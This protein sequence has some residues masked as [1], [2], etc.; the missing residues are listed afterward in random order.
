MANNIVININ[1]GTAKYNRQLDQAKQKMR[2]TFGH[3]SVSGVQATS[4]ALRTLEG[5]MTN[6]IRAVERFL[7]TTLKLG[8]ALQAAFPLIGAAA[9]AG[10]LVELTSK[11]AAFFKEI[12]NA[13]EKLHGAF[14]DLNQ[15]LVVTN[16]ALAVSNARLENE[17]A[18]LSGQPTNNLKVALLEAKE[19]ADKLNESLGK[20]IASAYKLVDEQSGSFFKRISSGLLGKADF[21]DIGKELGGE[22]GDGGFRARIRGLSGNDAA[23]AYKEEIAKFEQQ[24]Q[25]AQNS[26]EYGTSDFFG[27]VVT[28]DMT[29]R[30]E[31][32]KGELFSL[33]QD[34][35]GIALT[36]TNSGLNTQVAKLQ[37]KNQAANLDK[38]FADKMAELSA[39]LDEVKA[40]M[41][42]VGSDPS[43]Q[44]VA[45]GAAAAAKDILE[46]NKALAKKHET[47][48][49]LQAVQVITADSNIASAEAE[50]K[51]SEKITETTKALDE[52][53]AQQRA[54]NAVE[55]S[56]YEARRNAATESKLKGT[57]GA[58]YSDSSKA[59][60]IEAV[61]KKLNEEADLEHNAQLR[62]ESAELA[63]QITLYTR[64]AQVAG[65]F[66]KSHAAQIDAEVAKMRAEGKY[67]EEQIAQFIRLDK[68]KQ[69]AASA[70][71]SAADVLS[72]QGSQRV[73][74]AAFGG[75]D[76]IRQAEIQ[77]AVAE[78]AAKGASAAEQKTLQA[79]LEA[80][81][82]AQ[83]AVEAAKLTTSYRDQMETLDREIAAIREQVA[84]HGADVETQTALRNLEDQRLKLAQQQ[85]L[86][87]DSATAG[88]RAFFLEMET[89]AETVGKITYDS[90]NEALDKTSENLS[91]ML[92]G[93]KPK[94][95]WGKAFGDEFKS[96][97]GDLT[98]NTIHSA[99][100]R[101]LGAIGKRFGIN[102]PGGKP[103]GTSG[104]P[105][106]VIVDG[107][108]SSGGNAVPN[109]L[110]NIGGKVFGSGSQGG[111]IFSLLGGMLS[112][113]SG[114]AT[115]A[116]TSAISFPGFA[117]GG[118]PQGWAMVG[119]EGPELAYFGAGGHV[120]SN[121]DTSGIGRT[122][123]H[124]S[125]TIHA[126][127]AQ[128]GA[129][130]RIAEAVKQA[131]D[132]AV[133]TS[134]RA[135]HERSFRTPQRTGKN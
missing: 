30:L 12:Q 112:G 129:E 19:A 98:K 77:N 43:M 74:G 44:A 52:R 132:S 121:R 37:D 66:S 3:G 118:D 24:I 63:N 68:L 133:T 1:A 109:P 56:G 116:V 107:P 32:L 21:K 27:N 7:A 46:L 17:I 76:A 127:G 90:L 131:H 123:N 25:N 8:P 104:N 34:L 114:A 41:S 4:A 111:G 40:K 65:D 42:A 31:A 82:Q 38:P 80:E 122:T 97:G 22:N 96:I 9:L 92:T 72:I 73:A 94:G 91:N 62:L 108:G 57:F 10:F 11:A 103:D 84:L 88:V 6:N 85:A 101:G 86:Q 18:S 54:L 120:M 79:K 78:A 134:L 48:N 51:W 50:L 59:A 83:V 16:D 102:V 99:L 130:N 64:L 5:N 36:S 87:Q 49:A 100:Q 2:E 58:D 115:T 35:K 117:S 47:L 119:E 14:A 60:E 39:R 113:G 55:A 26:K 126:P 75:Q 93:K 95:G 15:S 23:A 135:Q 67:T 71:R 124:F 81:Y 128:I 105:F 29:A 125:Y 61:R 53:I 110:G 28:G 45:A 70:A 13:P 89:Q 33:Q 106:H 20:S 69:D